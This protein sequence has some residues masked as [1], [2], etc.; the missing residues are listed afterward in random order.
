MFQ[1]DNSTAVSAIPAP[2]PAGPPGY[3]TD[4]NP[5]TG[6]SAS[7]VPAEFLNALMMEVLN[8][9]VAGGITPAKGQYNQLALA[10]SKITGSSLVW[11]NI[12]NKPTTISEFGITDAYTKS[13][14]DSSLEEKADKATTVSGY[15]ITDALAVGSGGWLSYA[16]AIT[17][18]VAGITESQ[19]FSGASGATTDGPPAYPNSVGL[20]IIFANPE[21]GADI[22]VSIN[23]AV[24]TLVFRNTGGPAPSGWRVVWHDGNFTPA[25]KIS[26]NSC[27][28]AGF[29]GGDKTVPYMKHSD[30]TVV[31][32]ATAGASFGV[33]QTRQVF[34]VGTE[35]V[36]GTTYYNTT[37]RPIWIY[38]ETNTSNTLGGMGTLKVGNTTM[39]FPWAWYS[40]PTSGGGGLSAIVLP[41]ESY[42]AT[43]VT[44]WIEV[45]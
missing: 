45:R 43:T 17:G 10:I 44:L 12:E 37:P 32:L 1:I 15:G 31:V 27:P 40:N 9:L 34:A 2:T 30:G 38:L 24:G 21:Y 4:G 6:A 23:E 28:D 8:V 33:G 20:H 36:A 29:A 25:S 41:G 22:A 18:P 11:A 14:M 5:A 7:I 3:F 26:G 35:R 19:L 16:P 39:K 13:Q 42:V